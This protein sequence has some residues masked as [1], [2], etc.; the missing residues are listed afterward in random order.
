[1]ALPKEERLKE[2]A[3]FSFLFKEGKSIANRTLVLY[4]KKFSPEVR[5][6]GFT[7]GKKIGGAVI[8]NRYKRKMVAAYQLLLPNVQKGY[9]ML[10]IARNTI[11]NSDFEQIKR[12]EKD[13]LEK[14]G[15]W[16]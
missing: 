5:Q 9:L 4:Y 8:R 15:I 11:L 1:M 13:L 3:Q 14:A 12:S 6:A 2:S 10:F 7:V 16:K